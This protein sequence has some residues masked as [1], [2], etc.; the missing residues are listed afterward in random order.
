MYQRIKKH[1]NPFQIYQDKLI[2]E[3][4]LD[5][6]RGDGARRRGGRQVEAAPAERTAS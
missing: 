1:P 4:L 6:V 2:H 5:R 3:G